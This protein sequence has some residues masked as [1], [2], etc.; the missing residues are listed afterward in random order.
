[1]S[2]REINTQKIGCA[3]FICK[4]TNVW[5]TLITSGIKKQICLDRTSVQS[6]LF[7]I[8]F[9]ISRIFLSIFSLQPSCFYSIW[10]ELNKREQ[11]YKRAK[12]KNSTRTW[13]TILAHSNSLKVRCIDIGNNWYSWTQMQSYLS[14]GFAKKNVEKLIIRFREPFSIMNRWALCK[15]TNRFCVMWK[16][17]NCLGITNSVIRKTI[18]MVRNRDGPCPSIQRFLL[19]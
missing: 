12:K 18:R 10:F 17:L 11:K 1:M 15:K 16:N 14:C 13:R 8:F 4:N 2:E 7:I 19:T 3:T 9:F 5:K 6:L